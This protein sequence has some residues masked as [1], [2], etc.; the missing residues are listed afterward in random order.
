MTRNGIMALAI[1][2]YPDGTLLDCWDSNTERE[3]KRARAVGDTLALFVVRELHDVYEEGASDEQQR[4]AAAKALRRAAADLRAV[5]DALW[6]GD[7]E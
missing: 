5:A 6:D 2:A 4:K 3:S 7:T 1:G